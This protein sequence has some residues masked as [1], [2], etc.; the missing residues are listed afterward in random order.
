MICTT[1]EGTSNSSEVRSFLHL[2]SL[3][4]LSLIYLMTVSSPYSFANPVRSE[5]Q[6]PEPWLQTQTRLDTS[7]DEP[8]T[9]RR[10]R[11]PSQITPL[12]INGVRDVVMAVSI[13]LLTN[14]SPISTAASRFERTSPSP[15]HGFLVN[16]RAINQ[17]VSINTSM[18]QST[19]NAIVGS[20]QADP[21]EKP[22]MLE[23]VP[24]TG[25]GQLP[26]PVR[27]GSTSVLHVT[28]TLRR[29]DER[30]DQ[31]H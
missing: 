19:T 15:M 16:T 11:G 12:R 1:W 21:V 5:T 24:P 4:P 14:I 22:K 23:A 17:N 3:L 6:C 13:L 7:D 25:C 31:D 29:G 18:A 20:L 27:K 8:P 26:A 10:R 9:R 2:I 28:D 30:D